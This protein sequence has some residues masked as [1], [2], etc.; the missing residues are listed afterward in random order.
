MSAFGVLPPAILV[1]WRKSTRLGGAQLKPDGCGSRSL[2]ISDLP[3]WT[4]RHAKQN[5]ETFIR[6]R[7]G[8]Y[9]TT[10]WAGHVARAGLGRNQPWPA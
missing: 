9:R 8:C 3:D 1:L 6:Q 2:D 5:H 4:Q 7:P 10:G